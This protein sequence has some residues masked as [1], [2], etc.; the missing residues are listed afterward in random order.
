MKNILLSSKKIFLTAL[1]SVF[2]IVFIL[3][4]IASVQYYDKIFRLTIFVLLLSLFI[5]FFITKEIKIIYK[6]INLVCEPEPKPKKYFRASLYKYG[7]LIHF[8]IVVFVSLFLYF[9]LHTTIKSHIYFSLI[10]SIFITLTIFFIGLIHYTTT[11]RYIYDFRPHYKKNQVRIYLKTNNLQG[12]KDYF[13][14]PDK[15]NLIM[16]L[17]DMKKYFDEEGN[18]QKDTLKSEI[19]SFLHF[20]HKYNYLKGIERDKDLYILGQ[21]LYKISKSTMQKTEGRD[22]DIFKNI[23]L[24]CVKP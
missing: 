14:Y 18:P 16:Q 11:K 10:S 21:N 20:L 3:S 5:V 13:I 17:Y 8:S 9:Y 19:S 15:F 1:I 4:F 23:I 12:L 2:I 6:Y 22:T 24:E 7:F